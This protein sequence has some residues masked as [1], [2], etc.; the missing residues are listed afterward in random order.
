MVLVPSARNDTFL[1][2]P[3]RRPQ[4]FSCRRCAGV[5]AVGADVGFNEQLCR[6]GARALPPRGPTKF[7]SQR[8][9]H[10]VRAF[11]HRAHLGL[12]NCLYF[13]GDPVHYFQSSSV[14]VSTQKST[15]DG[16]RHGPGVTGT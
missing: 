14:A 15:R 8:S 13:S 11:D 4:H 9:P 16:R 2:Q 5:P 10:E 12:P 1:K 3:R 6:S 7:P